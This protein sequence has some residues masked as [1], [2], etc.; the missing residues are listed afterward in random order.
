MRAETA[1]RLLWDFHQTAAFTSSDTEPW[2][3]HPALIKALGD[4]EFCEG[5]NRFVVHR[6]AHQPHRVLGDRVEI[7][8]V[9]VLFITGLLRGGENQLEI[10]VANLWLNRMIGDAAL[11]V[12]QRL[13]WSTYEPFTKDTPLPVSG[14]IGPVTIKVA[15]VVQVLR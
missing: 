3:L 12:D 5:V 7:R 11:P 2:K 8:R 4:Y 14:L 10:R 9:H 13:T 15:S 6:Y 1:K